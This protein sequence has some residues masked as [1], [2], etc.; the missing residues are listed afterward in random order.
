MANHEELVEFEPRLRALA[1]RLISDP[2]AAEEALQETYVVALGRPNGHRTANG[3]LRRILRSRVRQWLRGERRRRALEQSLPRVL[4]DPASEN[5]TRSERALLRQL[6]LELEHLREPYRTTLRERF[7]CGTSPVELAQRDGIPVRTVHTRITRGLALLRAALE[8]TTGR[9]P[10]RSFVLA[11]AGRLWKRAP[12]RWAAAILALAGGAWLLDGLARPAL[13]RLAAPPW[14]GSDAVAV[15]SGERTAATDLAGPTHGS[16]AR[17]D[18]VPAPRAAPMQVPAPPATGASVSGRVVDLDG[19]GVPEL[20]VV[21]ESGVIERSRA[22]R[23]VAD[24][25]LVHAS[26]TRSDG[27]FRI[28]IGSAPPEVADGRRVHA[29]LVA[30]GPR[31]RTVAAGLLYDLSDRRPSQVIVAP[32]A[33]LEGRVVDAAGNAVPDAELWLR[34]PESFLTRVASAPFLAVPTVLETRSASDG[35]F[36]FEDAYEMSGVQLEVRAHGHDERRIVLDGPAS[37]DVVVSEHASGARLYGT[38]CDASGAPIEGRVAA[39]GRLVET[40]GAGRFELDLTGLAAGET[41]WGIAPGRMP[42]RWSNDPSVHEVRLHVGGP[43]A[44]I[45]GRV[46]D[47]EGRP[48]AGAV[49]WTIDP[50]LIGRDLS[51]WFAEAHMN[52]DP[53]ADIPF[54]VR[55]DEAGRF[56]LPFLLER[57]YRLGALQPETMCAGQSA[58]PIAAGTRDVVLRLSTSVPRTPVLGRVVDGRGGPIPGAQVAVHRAMIHVVAPDG[59]KLHYSFRGPPVEVDEDGWFGLPSLPEGGCNLV[60]TAPG[61]FPGRFEL[62]RGAARDYVEAALARFAQLEV[63]WSSLVVS[64]THFAVI[65]PSGAR[66][67]LVLPADAGLGVQHQARVALARGAAVQVVAPECSSGIVFLD[68]E[69]EVARRPLALSAERTTRV[70]L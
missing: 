68:G 36:R 39:A 26:K 12:A 28:A 69:R 31:H 33:F 18:L 10:R 3:W 14:S 35:S 16:V 42:A 38:L 24:G 60:V 63:R 2:E 23:F 48:A 20:D 41:I 53:L 56:D 46:E 34:L 51:D 40:D 29:R 57:P 49:V 13:A 62:P 61:F 25:M 7:L 17:D 9:R 44:R 47:D 27:T 8:R 32:D 19:V 50:T 59:R 37:V 4:T 6:A 21:Y 43:A 64:A 15:R 30:R 1:R 67:D 65:G 11:L 55:C 70:E 54:R 45:R 22:N 66:L 58:Q 5:R 52:E